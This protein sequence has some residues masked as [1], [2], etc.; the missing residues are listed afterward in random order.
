MKSNPTIE[1]LI[2]EFEEEF[3]GIPPQ[4]H[5]SNHGNVPTKYTEK[6]LRVDAIVFFIRYSLNVVAQSVRE[7]D[8]ALIM[9]MEKKDLDFG[10]SIENRM[11]VAGYNLAL[12]E[13]IA[14]I[15]ETL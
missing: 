1:A 15:K 9:K 14:K 8:I 3:I 10:I 5:T 7:E 6:M 13:A 11:M 2:K 12:T 4:Y